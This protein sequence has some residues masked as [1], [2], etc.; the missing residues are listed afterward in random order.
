M[1]NFNLTICLIFAVFLIIRGE[2]TENPDSM[3]QILIHNKVFAEINLNSEVKFSVEKM[4]TVRFNLK[5]NAPGFI[6]EIQDISDSSINFF[7]KFSVHK[8]YFRK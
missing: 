2:N 3:G 4:S 6:W 7:N 1:K 5:A 8:I